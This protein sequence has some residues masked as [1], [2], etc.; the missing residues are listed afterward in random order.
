MPKAINNKWLSLEHNK[1]PKMLIIIFYAD[2]KG[3]SINS[4]FLWIFYSLDNLLRDEKH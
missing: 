3:Q 4:F 2:L 1:Y